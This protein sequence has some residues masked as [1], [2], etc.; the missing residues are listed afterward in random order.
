MTVSPEDTVAAWADAWCRLDAEAVS[1]LFTDD[2]TYT[3]AL[4]G[5]LRDLPRGFRAATRTWR[6]CR[7]DDLE[8]AEGQADDEAA[9]VRATYRFA[10]RTRHGKEVAYSAEATFRL[11]ATDQGWR[12]Q[13]FHESS[14]P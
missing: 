9:V 10:G 8:V 3:A 14:V 1:A 13:D 7:L 12:I 2:A 4:S 6:E 5:T 11:L